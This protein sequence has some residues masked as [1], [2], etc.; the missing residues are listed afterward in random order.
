MPLEILALLVV[1]GVGGVV[2]AVHLSGGTVSATLASQ[3]EAVG[4]F[5]LDFAETAVDWT[6]ITAER[7]A[8]FLALK[9]GGA[10][11]V[12]AIG[13]CYL[14]RYLSPGSRFAC[15][16][17][18]ETGLSLDLDDISWRGGNFTFPTAAERD[19]VAGLLESMEG[20]GAHDG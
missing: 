18:G 7:D 12:R 14:T 20:M 11:I 1:V 19:R 16:R 17:K 6:V 8:A 10:G 13:D 3:K 2:L 5:H 4:R 15:E 9:N